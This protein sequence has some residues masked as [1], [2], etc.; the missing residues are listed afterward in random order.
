M[1][2]RLIEENLAD[3]SADAGQ[4]LSL[5]SLA[6]VEVTS[7][8]SDFPVDPVFG[9][10]G[11][12][13]WKAA[14]PGEQTVRLV[15]DQPC[16]IHRIH[17][18]FS[19]VMLDRTQEFVLEWAP[20]EGGPR[21]IVRQQWNFSQGGSSIE[22]EDYQVDLTGVSILQLTIKPDITNGRAPATLSKF[23]VA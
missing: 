2:K 12:P 19:E 8:H 10:G 3:A 6:S 22:V 14:G 17:L 1:R 13:G 7:E 15:F 23:R 4:W 21:E 9:S 18:E 5:E 11:G 16:P 20:Q